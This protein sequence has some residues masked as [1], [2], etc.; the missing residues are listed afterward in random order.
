MIKMILESKDHTVFISIDGANIIEKIKAYNIDIILIDIILPK[1]NGYE[2]IDIILKDEG[3]KDLP[4]IMVSKVT[5][6]ESVKTA[7][8]MGAFDYIK[9][10]VEPLETIARVDSALR[11]KSKQDLL[12]EFADKDSMT[13][14]Y[15]R[16]Y[17]NRLLPRLFRDRSGFGKGL[18][19]AMIDC[20]YFKRINDTYG[21]L[22]GDSVLI[23]VANTL[24]QSIRAIDFACRFGGEE[25]SVL[26][27]DTSMQEGVLVCEIIRDKIQ[28]I[29]HVIDM[30]EFQVTVSIGV[31]HMKQEDD[32]TYVDFINKADQALYKAKNDGRNRVAI[33]TT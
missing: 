14:L 5:S 9:K 3:T 20:D 22:A 18:S 29:K 25:F 31:S 26:M 6:G 17:F 10:P 8:D 30:H 16:S 1:T 12:K 15:N 13:K 32:M 11:L 4:I 33:S 21:H 7:L 19:L 23:S 27:P 28:K 24:Q 2:L